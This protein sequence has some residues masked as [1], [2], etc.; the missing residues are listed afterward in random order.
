MT[1]AVASS[2]TRLPTPVDPVNDTM[3]TSGWLTSASPASGPAPTTTL[4]TPA[5]IPAA[6]QSSASISEVN[7]VISAGLSTIVLPAAMAGRIFHIAIWSG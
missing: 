3:D 6:T 7:G 1:L 2:M 4:T 5:G